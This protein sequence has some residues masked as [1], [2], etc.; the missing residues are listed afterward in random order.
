MAE[1]VLNATNEVQKWDADFFSAY[2]RY[3]GFV[4]YMGTSYNN[5][6]VV[7]KEL[8]LSPSIGGGA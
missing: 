3:S 8:A 1:F 6:I 4:P 5:V 2:V 7:K